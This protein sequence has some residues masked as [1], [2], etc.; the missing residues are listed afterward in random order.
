MNGMTLLM[1]LLTGF[2]AFATV[3][4][5]RDYRRWDREREAYQRYVRARYAH[6]GLTLV[7]GGDRDAA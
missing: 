1:A 2:V 4:V 7:K 5:V 3:V 6:Q